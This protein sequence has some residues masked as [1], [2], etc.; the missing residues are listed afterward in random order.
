MWFTFPFSPPHAILFFF[1]ISSSL[2]HLLQ[3]SSSSHSS[4]KL[5]LTFSYHPSFSYNHPIYAPMLPLYPFTYSA[6]Y[7]LI[8]FPMHWLFYFIYQFSPCCFCPS[9]P[10]PL[11]S[12]YHLLLSI[13]FFAI[14]HSL[15]LLL[16]RQISCKHLTA[17]FTKSNF[18][19]FSSKM[20][21]LSVSEFI[22]KFILEVC[23]LRF[24]PSTSHR[25]I[26]TDRQT[27]L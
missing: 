23:L 12:T 11:I 21:V 15:Y 7:L 6:F 22:V 14:L 3:H 27:T 19:P 17:I 2:F 5:F 1:F 10:P 24:T 13:S 20:Y 8:L 16:L 18:D 25:I 9:L 4:P 26:S